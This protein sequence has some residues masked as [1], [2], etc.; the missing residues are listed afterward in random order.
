MT[1][2]AQT[3]ISDLFDQLIEKGQALREAGV[4]RV[5]IGAVAV[6]LLPLVEPDP[7][8]EP[9]MPDFHPNPLQ[10]PSLYPELG[11]RIPGYAPVDDEDEQ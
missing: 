9:Q 5:R 2:S 8:P 4:R 3:S 7:T 11:G 10:D 6:E 1:T